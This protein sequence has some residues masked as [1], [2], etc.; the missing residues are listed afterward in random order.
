MEYYAVA[1]RGAFRCTH[2]MLSS[3]QI[4]EN[5]CIQPSTKTKNRS[6]SNAAERGDGTRGKRVLAFDFRTSRQRRQPAAAAHSAFPD[7]KRGGSLWVLPC[8]H[9]RAVVGAWD[10]KR[11]AAGLC[12]GAR[13]A[14]KCAPV[15]HVE[16]PG[17]RCRGGRVPGRGGEAQVCSRCG[18]RRADP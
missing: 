1:R 6:F 11:N 5:P 4:A 17:D 14:K 2:K 3:F 16:P 10:G 13:A 12:R 9:A 15:V 18:T 8:A 7:R